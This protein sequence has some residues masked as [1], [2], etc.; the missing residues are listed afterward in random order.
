M[1]LSERIQRLAAKFAA[2]PAAQ[3][4][5]KAPPPSTDPERAALRWSAAAPQDVL[6]ASRVAQNAYKANPQLVDPRL[7]RPYPT[8]AWWQ[9][10]IVE[11][12]DQPVPTMPYLIKCL[13]DHLSVCMPAPLEQPSYVA[14]VWHD[15]WRI[16]IAS[17]M[18]RVTRY[19]PLSVTVE[20]T[21]GINTMAT[22]CLAKGMVC[23]TVVFDSPSVLALT[24]VHAVVE[25]SPGDGYSVVRLNNSAAWLVCF[26]GNTT[27]QQQGTSKLVSSGPIGSIRLAFLANG[28]TPEEISTLL[29]SS[30]P[31]GGTVN[32]EATDDTAVFE[33]TWQTAGHSDPLVCA[34]PH[35]QQVLEGKWVDCVGPYWTTKG[36]MRV[37]PGRWRLIEQLEPLGFSGPTALANEHKERLRELVSQDAAELPESGL[38]P[39]PYFFGKALAR[40]ARIALIA[41]EVGAHES[42]HAALQT[43]TTWFEPWLN[44]TNP[45]PLLYDTEWH[46]MVSQAGLNDGN[47]DF[48][49]GRYND[50]HFHY[51]YF[52]YAAAVLAV[53]NPEWIAHHQAVVDL[54][55]RDY[56]SPTDEWFPQM[57][58]FDFYDGH[59]W[60]AGLFAFADARNQESTS[61]AINAYYAAYLYAQA[62]NR[63]EIAR[64]ARAVLQMEAR[65][66]R[67][68]WHVGD[69][70][71]SYPDVY[72]QDKAVVGIRW[73]T[74]YDFATFFGANPEY[75]Y[76]IQMLPYTPAM[77]LLLKREWIQSIWPR[78]LQRVAEQAEAEPWREIIE[79]SYAVVDRNMAFDRVARI[80][81]HDDGNSASNSYYWI[82]TAP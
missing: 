40:A 9:N 56:C 25:V 38:P 62:T 21:D 48:G 73:S 4:Q 70:P 14:S 11:Q 66:S 61:E 19:D 39:D 30:V 23:T 3:Q 57:R 27:V 5:P 65:A 59:S 43:L 32:I 15:D 74:K 44:G 77:A 50:H 58:H 41:H 47:A 33:Y 8:N 22:A 12:G 31:T 36:M 79:L 55:A 42:C 68:Y 67:T 71:D 18:R 26:D 13:T 80:K 72:S 64:F 76:G 35:H 53:L 17:S 63:K 51:G 82:A 75:I 6:S 69:L 78:C 2:P 29:E 28:G 1:P 37:L 60:A 46:G 54:L 7:Q 20:Y 52:V 10:L 81:N 16:H 34:L 24:T 49:Q 45:N